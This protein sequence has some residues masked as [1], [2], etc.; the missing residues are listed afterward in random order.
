MPR[1]AIPLLR[2]APSDRVLDSAF[3]MVSDL[4]T[5]SMTTAQLDQIAQVVYRAALQPGTSSVVL[6]SAGS[7]SFEP[8]RSA[9][10]YPSAPTP[11]LLS[12][13]FGPDAPLEPRPGLRG[14]SVSAI[15]PI[16]R[17]AFLVVLGE[18]EVV[19]VV[20]APSADEPGLV[21]TVITQDPLRVHHLAR[22]L[23]E[24]IPGTTA[25]PPEPSDLSEAADDGAQPDQGGHGLRLPWRRP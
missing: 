8:D 16:A 20:A 9:V 6:A 25:Q 18:R 4:G 17:E 21:D 1:A 10:E 15:D 24:R 2:M 3:D 12:V 11:P 5:T 22:S 13:L 23:F 7:Q 14:V 19:A